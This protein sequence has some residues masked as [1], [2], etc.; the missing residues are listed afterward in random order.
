MNSRPWL[1][2]SL[3]AL[4]LSLPASAGSSNPA[5][6][7]G[8][9]TDDPTVHTAQQVEALRSFPRRVMVR[10][11]FDKENDADSYAASVRGMA[12]VADVMGLPVDSSDMAAMDVAAVRARIASYLRVLGSTVKVWE[13]G[14][15]INGEW[16][17]SQV[18]AKVEAMYDAVKSAGKPAALTL[19]YESPPPAEHDMLPW[20]DANIP[21][22]HRMRQGLDYVL[23]SYYEDQ[24]GGHRLSQP[25]VDHIFKALANRFP[26]A[27]L[28]F[29]EFG[30]GGARSNIPA[31]E[32][33]RAALIRRFYSYQV[34]SLPQYVGGFFYWHFRQTMAPRSQRDWSV[35][36]DMMKAR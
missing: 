13:V 23:V 31:D 21:V 30:W 19:Y 5:W 10:T 34:P 2:L 12:A 27:K 35:L 25:E 16:L 32:A 18:M 3:L 1:P 15:E 28:G 36:S 8:V 14:N 26:N 9:T 29:A 24:N 4:V 6:I 17:G 22:G 33:Q 7:W 11:V 20:V